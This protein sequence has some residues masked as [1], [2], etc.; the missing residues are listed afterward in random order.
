MLALNTLA[1]VRKPRQLR[2]GVEA[3]TELAQLLLRQRVRIGVAA[4]PAAQALVAVSI[5][6]FCQ[7]ECALQNQVCVRTAACRYGQSMNAE[8]R[9]KVIERRA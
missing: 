7:E 9:S 1:G 3:G 5:A 2:R 8:P 4:D 6:T